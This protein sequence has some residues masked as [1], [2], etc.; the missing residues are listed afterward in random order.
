MRLRSMTLLL[1]LGLLVAPPLSAQ[2][3]LFGTPGTGGNCY[4]FGCMRSD[5]TTRYQQ[6][7]SAS[8]FTSAVFIESI[9]FFNSDGAGLLDNV[10][11][12]VRL[13]TTS[14][15]VNGLA[16]DPDDSFGAVVDVFTLAV[17]SGPAGT[18]LVFTGTPFY[19]DPSMGNL[20][21]D[22]QV[23]GG[24]TIQGYGGAAFFD[25]FSSSTVA[26]RAFGT[27]GFVQNDFGNGLVTEFGTAPTEVVPEPI[28]MVLLG[29]GLLGVGG[30]A[31]RRRR[32]QELDTV[33]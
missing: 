27:D 31:R 14:T 22:F 19:Y 29:S 20:L 26:N 11:F 1:G 9:R 7:Y 12:T 33:A 16:G 15:A 21:V 28:T 23:T 32:E 13:S 2:T 4:P 8:E 5:G 3:V 25:V 10:N 6:I 24:G 30:A 18:E 17:L